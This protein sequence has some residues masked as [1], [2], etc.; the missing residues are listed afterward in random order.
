VLTPLF[1][2]FFPKKKKEMPR[3]LGK[4]VKAFET[5]GDPTLLLK[6]SSTKRGTEMIIAL[7]MSDWR[8]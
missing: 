7:A 3:V 4:L 6:R 8:C 2:E 5:N 1:R